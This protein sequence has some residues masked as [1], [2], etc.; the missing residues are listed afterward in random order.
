MAKR[1]S[2]RIPV[3]LM[4]KIISGG[5]TYPGFIHNVSEGGIGY[6]IESMIDAEKNFSPKK[7]IVL[8]LQ[9]P[10]GENLDLNCEIVMYS[11]SSPDDKRLTIGMKI[12]DPPEKYK[13]FVKT[14]EIDYINKKHD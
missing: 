5:K 6:L 3:S 11:K 4:A 13:E 9:I 1:L 8:N 2:T 10:S 14:L 7:M 12:I